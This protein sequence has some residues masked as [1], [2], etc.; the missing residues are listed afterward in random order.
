[1]SE[2]LKLARAFP[3]IN[4]SNYG[5]QGVEA[6]NHWGGQ[7]V[8]MLRTQATENERLAS[9]QEAHVRELA[10]LN[11]RCERLRAER[12]ALK[13]DASF[14]I[15]KLFLMFDAY[16]NGAACYEEPEEAA[17]YIGNA[18]QLDGKDL[19]DIADFLN[20]VTPIAAI[21]AAKEQQ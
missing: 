15:S 10:A 11:V 19:S 20:R 9:N 7:A 14:A 8:E 13:A 16:E 17:G 18:V 5:E 12:D 2:A 3:E 6:V 4:M 21:D 1:M